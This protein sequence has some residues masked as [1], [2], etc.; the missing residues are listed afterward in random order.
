M[1]GEVSTRVLLSTT[2][3]TTL[4]KRAEDAG[5]NAYELGKVGG[6]RLIFNYEGIQVIDIA[7]EEL[8]SSWGQG[9]PKLLS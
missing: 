3:A 6:K 8:E 2:A 5:L 7:I 4:R 9:L 1:F